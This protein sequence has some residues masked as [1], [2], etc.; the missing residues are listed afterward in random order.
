MANKRTMQDPRTSSYNKKME[1]S[2]VKVRHYKEKTFTNRDLGRNRNQAYT[3]NGTNNQGYDRD[4]KQFTKTTSS[5]ARG[6]MAVEGSTR[7][8]G[9]TWTFTQ[10]DDNGNTV[11]QS[12][13]SQTA[14]R[15]QRYYDVRVGLGL[16]GG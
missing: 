12:G 11:R 13:R 9:N 15:R 14:T 10:K 2:G 3:S 5:S 16:M 1:G 7:A 6:R 8:G 4:T